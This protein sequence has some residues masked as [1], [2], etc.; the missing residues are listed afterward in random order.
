M[1][2]ERLEPPSSGRSPPFLLAFA[3]QFKRLNTEDTEKPMRFMEKEFRWKLPRPEC[4][5]AGF[6]AGTARPGVTGTSGSEVR[7][8]RLARSARRAARRAVAAQR[9]GTHPHAWA[10]WRRNIAERGAAIA[11]ELSAGVS[12]SQPVASS[13]ALR[14]DALHS[15]SRQVLQAVSLSGMTP[16]FF[17]FR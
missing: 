15:P 16:E 14:I 3:A 17:R 4:E 8:R 5:S 13:R 11:A 12:R 6:D 7:S 1:P 10:D 2:Q 9:A